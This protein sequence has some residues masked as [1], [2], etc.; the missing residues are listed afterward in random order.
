LGNKANKNFSLSIE[1]LT[2]LEDE[3]NSENYG[4]STMLESILRE[5]YELPKEE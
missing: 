1:V 3:A 2:K 4:L 5:R